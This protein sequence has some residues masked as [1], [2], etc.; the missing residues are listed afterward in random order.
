MHPLDRA[1]LDFMNTNHTPEVTTTSVL[2]LRAWDEATHSMV[3]FDLRDVQQNL[4]SV[5]EL[6]ARNDWSNPIMQFTGLRDKNG[7]EIYEG[8]I[9][10]LFSC[11]RPVVFKNG[12]FGYE[13]HLEYNLD[14][15]EHIAFGKNAHFNWV[16]GKS[17]K[18]E[19]VGNI[20]QNPEFLHIAS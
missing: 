14:L 4:F 7:N 15:S 5:R 18:I 10:Q 9:V 11:K 17:D 12:C 20:Y 1:F 8:D 3:L 19:V 16:E 2:K 6:A 13:T